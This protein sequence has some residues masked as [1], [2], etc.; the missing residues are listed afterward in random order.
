MG[1]LA[2]IM[3]LAAANAGNAIAPLAL[4]GRVVDVEAGD[5]YFRAPDSI[6]AGLT[7]LRLRATGGHALWI[8]RLPR[9]KSPNDWLAATRTH[10][11]APWAETWA[12]PAF[13]GAAGTANATYHFTAGRYLLVCLVR[14]AKDQVHSQMGMVH[15]VVV[16]PARDSAPRLRNPDMTV[17]LSDYSFALSQPLRPGGQLVRLVNPTTHFHEF[18]LT[19]VLAGHTGAEALRWNPA[20]GVP[21]PDEDYGGV[22]S[23]PPGTSLLTTLDLPPGEYLLVCVPQLKHGM[24]KAERVVAGKRPTAYRPNERTRAPG[25]DG[26]VWNLGNAVP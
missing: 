9:G 2:V 4:P 5:F 20:S 18:R 24:L 11:L 22:S 25:H 3:S 13:P 21:R 16:V 10:D 7:T 26:G 19:R 15:L 17:T 23:L 14:D 1:L 6:P 12:G 8:V